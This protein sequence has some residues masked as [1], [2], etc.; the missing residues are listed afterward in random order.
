MQKG[1]CDEE[2]V[3]LLLGQDFQSEA[4]GAGWQTV[5]HCAVVLKVTVV[6][7]AAD[8]ANERAPLHVK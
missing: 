3:P 1:R 2:V 8:E 7:T 5:P 6:C 4:R